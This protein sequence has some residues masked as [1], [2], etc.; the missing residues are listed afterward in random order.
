MEKKGNPR[1]FLGV[2]FKCC[3]VYSR[4]Y[5]NKQQTAFVGWCPKCARQMRVN[6]SPDG[7]TSQFF[8]MT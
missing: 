2:M 3:K 6:I 5:I 1:P 8:E 7:S 4:I